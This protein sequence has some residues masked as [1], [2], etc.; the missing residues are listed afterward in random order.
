MC[1]GSDLSTGVVSSLKVQTCPIGPAPVASPAGF[2]YGVQPGDTLFLIAQRF[3]A[4]LQAIIA[5]NPQITNPTAIVA[6]QVVCVPAIS[7]A[8]DVCVL[9][10]NRT[11]PVPQSATGVAL[12]IQVPPEA[13]S[14]VLVTAPSGPVV[15]QAPFNQCR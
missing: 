4:S 12:V 5:A 13:A 11:A 14:N 7:P 15:L 10:L 9:L 1:C 3:G 2:L 8:I 6:A